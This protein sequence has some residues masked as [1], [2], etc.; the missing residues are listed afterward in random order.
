MPL[1][2]VEFLRGVVPTPEVLHLTHCTGMVPAIGVLEQLALLPSA[3]PVYGEDLLYLFYGRPAYKPLTVEG[4]GD[5]PEFLPVCFVLD[6]ALLATAKR[7]VPFDSG[8]FPRY[9]RH[10]GPNPKLK[11]YEVASDGTA[12][13]RMVSAFYGTNRRYFDQRPAKG[14]DDFPASRPT[15][16]AYARL[17][18]D[19]SLDDDDD[20]RGAIEVHFGSD[21]PLADTLRAIV[22]PP[23]MFED[24]AIETAL[25]ACPDVALL[26]YPTYG[27]HRPQDYSLLVYERV[28]TFLALQ[29][30]FG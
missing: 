17:I 28:D 3:C 25:A 15:A 2:F 13:G 4:A 30:A 12:P 7:V 1:T 24:P 8:G 26:S 18:A 21:V 20:R 6:P 22:A 27:R 29:G 14:V 10:L 16:R 5:M 11:D 23:L 19:R 9:R